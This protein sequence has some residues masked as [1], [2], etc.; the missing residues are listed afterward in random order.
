MK[1]ISIVMTTWMRE[2]ITTLALA[3]LATNTDFPYRLIIID[4]GSDP[5]AEVLYRS[6]A[7]VYHKFD[8]NVG[9]EAAKNYAMRFVDSDYFISTDND[10]LVPNL[11][12]SDWLTRLYFLIKNNPEYGAIALRPQVL[13]GT[14]DIFGETPPEIKE[15]SHVPGYMRIMKTDLVN[16]VGAWNDKRPLRGHEEYWIS[17]KIQDEGLKV[18]W[19]S[20]I[21]CYHVFGS[22]N[23][24]G[25]KDMTIEEHGDNPV[26]LPNDDLEEIPEK[27]RVIYEI[28]INLSVIIKKLFLMKYL[29]RLSY[30]KLSFHTGFS[31]FFF[32]MHIHVYMRLN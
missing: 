18:G 13:V 2:N 27:I 19:A 12:G 21:K 6:I 17:K 11:S 32:F 25:Y 8:E 26:Q 4:N 15:F 16:K 10:I 14:G 7:D 24:W 5:Y 28:T 3:S 9:L 1:P 30:G 31:E 29:F 20:Y 22:D 23:N